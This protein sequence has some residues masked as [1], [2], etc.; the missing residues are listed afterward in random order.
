MRTKYLIFLFIL[1]Q[2]ILSEKIIDINGI[3]NPTCQGSERL[4]FILSAT[5]NNI[6]EGD[7][8]EPKLKSN[9]RAYVHVVLI[10]TNFIVLLL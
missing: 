6:T 10:Q 8:F 9:N 4:T 2:C 3:S 7:Y 5:L 1:I